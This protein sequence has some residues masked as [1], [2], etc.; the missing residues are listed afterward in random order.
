MFNKH[1]WSLLFNPLPHLAQRPAMF[2]RGSVEEAQLA[3]NYSYPAWVETRGRFGAGLVKEKLVV[4]L[5]VTINLSYITSD[6]LSYSC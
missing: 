5:K 4:F 2:V 6:H 1:F 3:L